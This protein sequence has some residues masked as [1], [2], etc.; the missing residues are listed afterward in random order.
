[1]PATNDNLHRALRNKNDEFYT[2]LSDVEKECAHYISYFSDKVIYCNTDDENSAFWHYFVDNFENLGIKKVIATHLE[3]PQSYKLEYDGNSVIK[4]LLKGDGNYS[5]SECIEILDKVDIVVTNPP[6][7]K[8]KEFITLIIEHNKDLLVI[9]NE[10]AFSSTLLF[11]LLKD[12]KIWTG[13]NKVKTFFTPTGETK[14]FGNI[15]WFTNL[16]REEKPFIPLSKVYDETSYKR[17][18][19]FDAINVDRLT[20]IP[21]DYAGVMGVP[22]SLIGKYNP[23]QFEILG[24]AA[25]N[26]KAHKLNYNVAY[27]PHPLDRGGCGIVEGQRK[28]TRVFVYLKILSLQS[29]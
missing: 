2:Y 25:G 7:S 26:T 23:K 17:Y 1:L 4:T 3:S 10:N 8:S 20:D 29:L 19:N 6:F 11:P 16:P 28:Y 12:H 9:G 15:C 21:K 5:S 14:D 22:I 18:E 24:L 27:T 13:Y